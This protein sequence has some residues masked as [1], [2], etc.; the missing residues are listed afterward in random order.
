M[1]LFLMLHYL[2]L[3]Y[4][5][6][7]HV[8]LALFSVALFNVWFYM[9]F[10]LCYTH[11]SLKRDICAL[12]STNDMK[13]K[14]TLL[15]LL[16]K[17]CC[18]ASFPFHRFVLWLLCMYILCL[19]FRNPFWKSQQNLKID[20]IIQLLLPSWVTCKRWYYLFIIRFSIVFIF[21][22]KFWSVDGVRSVILRFIN[23]VCISYYFNMCKGFLIFQYWLTWKIHCLIMILIVAHFKLIL[24]LHLKV[25]LSLCSQRK[26][27]IQC[28]KV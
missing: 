22:S 4:L 8:N 6:L 28:W 18:F 16:D 26:Q 21:P 2:L 15:M 24:T 12:S 5:L 11:S 20:A 3:C 25:N 7:H 1:L 9:Y 27:T 19:C 23:I 13:L 10:V 14:L 17:R